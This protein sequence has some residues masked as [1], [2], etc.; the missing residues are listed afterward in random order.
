VPRDSLLARPGCWSSMRIGNDL[1]YFNIEMCDSS[2]KY[3]T[4]CGNHCQEEAQLDGRGNGKP[5]ASDLLQVFGHECGA[6]AVSSPWLAEALSY[7]C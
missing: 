1:N 6:R 4:A 7:E 2:N 5:L 3:L